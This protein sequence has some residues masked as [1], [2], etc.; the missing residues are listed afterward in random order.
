MGQTR[1]AMSGFEQGSASIGLAPEAATPRRCAFALRR[2]GGGALHHPPAR[3]AYRPGRPPDS[4]RS[5]S[6]L[7]RSA[8]RPR[9]ALRSDARGRFPT[10]VDPWRP[11]AEPLGD[12]M[13]VVILIYDDVE[14]LDIAGPFDVFSVASRVALR[15]QDSSSPPV[16]VSVSAKGG[17]Q[18]SARHGLARYTGFLG[19]ARTAFQRKCTEPSFASTRLRFG[20]SS[21]RKL[22]AEQEKRRQLGTPKYLPTR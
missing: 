6:W 12:A 20:G 10:H 1:I 4:M 11:P 18:V 21:R 22:K 5:A 14:V 2:H 17:K 3:P 19:T 7:G 16:A 13:H 8:A 9:S 15:A